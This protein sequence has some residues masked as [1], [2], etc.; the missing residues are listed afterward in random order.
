MPTRTRDNDGQ[1]VEERCPVKADQLWIA[2]S[3]SSPRTFPTFWKRTPWTTS[4]T[5]GLARSIN[6]STALLFC[7]SK[8]MLCTSCATSSTPCR[9][10]W[11][12]LSCA[13]MCAC[14]WHSKVVNEP[15]WPSKG[16]AVCKIVGSTG[17]DRFCLDFAHAV[18]ECV[19]GTNETQTCRKAVKSQRWSATQAHTLCARHLAQAH[20]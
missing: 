4:S 8:S 16:R 6:G 14:L 12:L 13:M 9:N 10:S 11:Y 3:E 1:G 7:G 2:E 19:Q 18:L 20:S 5:R 17:S 15:H